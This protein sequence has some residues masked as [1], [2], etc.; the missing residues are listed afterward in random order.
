MKRPRFVIP[1]PKVSG[2]IPKLELRPCTKQWCLF[3]N[4]VWVSPFLLPKR[5]QK[6]VYNLVE[7]ESALLSLQGELNYSAKTQKDR[8]SGKR[9]TYEK[10]VELQNQAADFCQSL[11]DTTKMV[12]RAM[13][14]GAPDCRNISFFFL[15]I[16]WVFA[17][18]S[19]IFPSKKDTLLGFFSAHKK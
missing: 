14:M 1:C 13:R 3:I 6:R 15:K 16:L 9:L 12:R 19:L 11:A 4:T 5:K 7:S 8:S 18:F 2:L 17:L 10:A